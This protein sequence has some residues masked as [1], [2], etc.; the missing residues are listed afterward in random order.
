MEFVRLYAKTNSTRVQKLSFLHLLNM[1]Y[2]YRMHMHPG[3]VLVFQQ[4]MDW[5]F[6]RGQYQMITVS[7]FNVF[8]SALCMTPG[9]RTGLHFV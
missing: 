1:F 3:S 4:Q 8:M 6:G 7:C 5:C 9:F 2:T